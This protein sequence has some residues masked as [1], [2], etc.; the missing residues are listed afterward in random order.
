[1]FIQA[2]CRAVDVIYGSTADNYIAMFALSEGLFYSGLWVT[3]A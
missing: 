3:F 2:L 1:M